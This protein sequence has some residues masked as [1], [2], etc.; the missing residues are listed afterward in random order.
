[1]STIEILNY[2]YVTYGISHSLLKYVGCL[3]L[4]IKC[5]E[6]LPSS[7]VPQLEARTQCVPDHVFHAQNGKDG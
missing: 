4:G 1:M 2:L 3:S 7:E 5:K 6:E